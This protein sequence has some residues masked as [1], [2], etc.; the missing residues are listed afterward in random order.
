M[1]TIDP[2]ICNI[3]STVTCVEANPE[4]VQSSRS[5]CI[6]S[7]SSVSKIAVGEAA[8]EPCPPAR[9]CA[10]ARPASRLASLAK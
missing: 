7:D 8:S 9:A 1:R 2:K 3:D 6:L 10:A 5:R 4:D